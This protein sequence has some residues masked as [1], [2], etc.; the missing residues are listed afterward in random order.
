MSPWDALPEHINEP[1]E[2]DG[3]DDDD[4]WYTKWRKQVKGWFAF[5]AIGRSKHKWANFRRYPKN[6]FKIGKGTW[7][8]ED[9]ENEFYRKLKKSYL[10][11]VQYKM[12]WHIA[13]EW[14]LYFH[15]HIKDWQF[16]AGLKLD[17]D[18]VYWAS[19]YFGKIW[20]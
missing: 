1:N 15:G 7:R 20:K 9:G 2:W 8:Y 5:S 3:K 16:Y 6:I 4:H 12:N 18:E 13:L 17:A 14:P 10:S 11:R 19:L